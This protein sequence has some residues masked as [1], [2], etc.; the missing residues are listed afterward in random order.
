V[1]VEASDLLSL[2]TS[3]RFRVEESQGDDPWFRQVRTLGVEN[4]PLHQFKNILEK[5]VDQILSLKT[6]DQ[7]KLALTWTFTKSESGQ[8]AR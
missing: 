4:G 6:I 5:M 8:A 3:L 2:L 7:I 1:A